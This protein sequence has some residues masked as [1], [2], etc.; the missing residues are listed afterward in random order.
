MR[1]VVWLCGLPV[2][3]SAVAQADVDVKKEIIDRC[4]SQM[5]QYGSAMVKA[6]VDQDLEAVEKI[7]RIPDQY[8]STV[9]R[10][11]KQMRQYGFS[12]VNACAEQDIE[13]DKALSKY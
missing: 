8:K 7:G 11:L 3:F 12:L 5:G 6:C 2:V 13:A 10:C 9:A 4:K 1:R